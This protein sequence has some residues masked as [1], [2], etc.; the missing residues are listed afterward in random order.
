LGVLAP[1]PD[2]REVAVP[3]GPGDH[4]RVVD[5]DDGGDRDLP[6][7]DR[8]GVLVEAAE[9]DGGRA[10]VAPP[11]RELHD[12]QRD[13]RG[14]QGHEVGHE[15]GAAPTLVGDPGE[16]PD[17]AEPDRRADGGQNEPDSGPPV[18]SYHCAS[19]QSRAVKAL[20]R[21]LTVSIPFTT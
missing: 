16:A 20:T 18:L 21:R 7:A 8:L 4:G 14:Q 17:V 2:E 12:E 5:R 11:D 13:A 1:L 19:L 15:E 10:L 3:G 6:P 9:R